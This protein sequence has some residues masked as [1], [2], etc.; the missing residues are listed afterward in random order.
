[1]AG[2][3]SERIGPPIAGNSAGAHIAD[4][5]DIIREQTRESLLL[6]RQ[7]I[8]MLLPKGDP[9]KPKLEDLMAALVAQQARILAIVSRL[10]MDM[11]AVLD[12]LAPVNGS[13]PAGR[14]PTSGSL[15]S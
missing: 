5:L 1:M 9:D 13:A 14:Q 4:D 10:G 15:R 8:E 11:S 7:L 6:L 12:L 3:A 2:A